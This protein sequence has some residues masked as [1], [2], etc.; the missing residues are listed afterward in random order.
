MKHKN[1]IWDGLGFPIVFIGF[2]TTK[3][4]EEVFPDI[5]MNVLQKKAFRLLITKKSRL[6]GNELKFIR[7]HLQR[8]QVELSRAINAASRSSFSQW[9]QK[10][11]EQTGMD[12]NTEI[13][14]RL[15][16]AKQCEE[17]A[18]KQGINDFYWYKMKDLIFDFVWYINKNIENI[19]ISA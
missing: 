3:I 16:M 11:D 2:S 15:F 12:I 18:I 4:G 7:F 17:S 6:T 13:M 10:R 1:F 5:D 14:I 8:T 19:S 9:E